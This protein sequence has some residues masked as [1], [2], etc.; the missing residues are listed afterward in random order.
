MILVKHNTTLLKSELITFR[1]ASPLE[2]DE[3]ANKNNTEQASK[4]LSNETTTK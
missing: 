3:S 1:Q 2:T 4:V